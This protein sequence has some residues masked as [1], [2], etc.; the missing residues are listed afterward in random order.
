MFARTY[1][2]KCKYTVLPP[3]TRQNY[4]KQNISNADIIYLPFYNL[5]GYAVA[6]MFE[7]L[8]YKPE[9]CGFDS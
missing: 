3:A 5:F 2:T 7:A 1:C 4:D 9:G 6:Q 8:R